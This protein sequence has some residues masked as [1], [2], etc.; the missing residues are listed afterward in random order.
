MKKILGLD[1][2][3]TSIGWALINEGDE[4]NEILGMGC[5]IIPYSENEAGDFKQGTGESKNHQRT[6][7]RT[8]R[9][10]YDRY[11]LR[12]HALRLTLEQFGLKPNSCHFNL[13]ALSLYGLRAKAIEE[14]IELAEI[15]RI[16]FHFN[17]RRGYKHGV[18]EES[19][20]KKQREF[21]EKINN[22][23]EQIKERYS[24]GQYFT[25]ELE[26]DPLFRIKDKV[27]PR[28]AYISEFNQIWAFQQQFYPEILTNELGARLRDE[29][30]YYQRPLKSQKGLVSIC[31]FEG[32]LTANGKTNNGKLVFAGPK[33]APRSSPLFQVCKIWE[34]I[35]NIS[36]TTINQDTNKYE[37][38]KLDLDQ[39]MKLFQYLDEHENLSE[40]KLFE[41]LEL[42]MGQKYFTNAMIKKR[43]IQGN[44]TKA[45]LIKALK[46]HPNLKDLMKMELE[47]ESY[48][49]VDKTTGEL[50]VRQRITPLIEADEIY[51]LW[52][53]LY[54]GQKERNYNL[55]KAKFNINNEYAEKLFEI[56]FTKGGYGNKSVKA[57]RHILPYLMQ[58]FVYSDACLMA[59]YRHSDSLTTDERSRKILK[60]KLDLLPKNSL[61]Q[62][63]VEKILNQMI[64]V[65]NA[66]I[67]NYGRPDEI[68]VELARELKQ[69][70]QE[71][72][73]YYN[74][75]SARDRQNKRIA[76][77][78]GNEYGVKGNKRNIEKWRLFHEV[79]GRCLYCNK[80]LTIT[81]LLRGV[82]ADIE[83]II[84]RSLYFD[85]S[86][87]NKTISHVECNKAKGQSTAFD[88]M[89]GKPDDQFQDYINRVAELSH[90]PGNQI[91][92]GAQCVVNK[93]NRTKFQR[94]MMERKDIPQDF[95]SRQ[96]R[97]TQYIARKAREIL[98]Q[99]ALNVYA[100]S[101]TV[102]ERL[103]HL[104]GWDNILM[105]L[106]LPKYRSIGLTEFI[107]SQNGSG[108]E[109]NERIIGWNKR[110]D[111]RHHAIDALTIACTKQGF[112]QRI[113]TLNS[114]HT[115]Q[116]IFAEIKDV[117]FK[118]KL[119]AL[120]K[121]LILKRPFPTYE[122]ENQ[123]SKVLISFKSG[124]KVATIGVRKR[125]V[126]GS[127]K[128]VQTGVII[129][130]GAL[131]EES[132]YGKIKVTSNAPL[133]KLFEAPELIVS[134]RVKDLI[135]KRLIEH[136]RDIKKAV[137]SCKAK[138]IF[139][140]SSQIPL[141]F[142][143]VFREEVVIKYPISSLKAKDLPS[144]VDPN[145]RDAIESRL[146][147][148]DFNEKTAFK[149]IENNPVW[150]DE[151]N[152]IPIKS[153]R[154]FTGLS[155]V[156]PLKTWEDGSV[157]GY[158]KPGNNHH[159]A[160]YIDEN[161]NK[162][163]HIVTFWHAVERKKYGFPVVIHNPVDAWSIA[164]NTEEL[165]Q[166][167]MKQLPL[168]TWRYILSFQ[169]NEM[170]FMGLKEEELQRAIREKEYSFLSQKLYRVQKIGA[171]DYTFRHHLETM[172]DDSL[173]AIKTGRFLRI[174]SIGTLDSY[175]PIK[176]KI[177]RV[178]KLL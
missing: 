93:L 88:F 155:S 128:T 32:F 150:C 133:K 148:F 145:V 71:R 135:T 52:H 16:L 38:I 3:S 74:N 132:V 153:V 163:E 140:E 96:L 98:E 12:R 92:D 17:Q 53:V 142:A 138:P 27:F 85:D 107:E 60:D 123:V 75:A 121:Y 69:S 162:H 18:K 67:E 166:S 154:C 103:R 1:L 173:G 47:V 66:I 87:S 62:P 118:E 80:Q 46:G 65:V 129:P 119:T 64:N 176:A 91:D 86:F 84:P 106:Q 8:Q 31:E 97:E 79:G 26:K 58:G 82:E 101:G 175:S 110:M 134:Q 23:Y 22:R 70:K 56:D 25:K 105:Q 11:Q 159:I 137:S 151:K 94:L 169:Q 44:L 100:T 90:S 141:E 147:Q 89:N 34:S 68:R 45:T 130:R 6:I 108:T 57:M 146:K 157:K 28:H 30:I 177:N 24:I 36:I 158:V 112:I 156:V 33:V 117:E 143:K 39:K 178:G 61:R 42:E 102:T 124:K 41:I 120:E 78:L 113:N 161:G 168:D 144:V 7:K 167:F 149:D 125:K 160:I 127:L 83:H 95:I 20:D 10:G 63:V 4:G 172:I 165:P 115:R 114:E 50:I 59:G 5:R 55:L 136:G 131:S 139:L 152:K 72:N 116:E 73:E 48:D 99:V 170:Y 37:K 111:N 43:G 122:V 29:I 174:R 51:Q 81:Q 9:K 126:D 35:N 19:G 49:L 14:K 164:L 76:E 171:S 15:G 109:N 21:V 54:S 77:R 40:K 13:T 104:W 2:G